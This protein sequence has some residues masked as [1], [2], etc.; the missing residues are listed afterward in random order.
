[1]SN[2]NEHIED[3]LKYYFKL[4]NS[5]HYA[6]LLKGNW[7]VGKTWLLKDVMKQLDS[8]DDHTKKYLY[9]SLYGVESFKDIENEFF[10]EL[11]PLLS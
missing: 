5:P 2:P 7:G 9:V 3:F 11:Y 10:R 8:P 6:V 1:M 4:K